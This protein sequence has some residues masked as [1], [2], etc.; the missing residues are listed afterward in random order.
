MFVNPLRLSYKRPKHE[1]RRYFLVPEGN[2]S[3]WDMQMKP[4]TLLLVSC[5]NTAVSTYMY[6]QLRHRDTLMKRVCRDELP[7]YIQ[8]ERM[9]FE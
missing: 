9:V 3:L 1:D 5:P 7:M 2:Y 6:V 4:I 8:S